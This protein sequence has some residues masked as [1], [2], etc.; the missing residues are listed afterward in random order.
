M[1]RKPDSMRQSR[2]NHEHR[3][4]G[5]VDTNRIEAVAGRSDPRN[6]VS[7]ALADSPPGN[8][9]PFG[10]IFVPAA[11]II[12]ESHTRGLSVLWTVLCDPSRYQQAR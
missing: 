12:G 11:E 3:H 1:S 10:S 5:W 2:R 7:G 6:C 4:I 8:T 9:G